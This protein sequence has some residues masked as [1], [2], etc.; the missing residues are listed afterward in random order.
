MSRTKPNIYDVADAA[1]V[2]HQT[3]SRVLNNHPSLRPETRQRVEAAMLNLGYIPSRAARA[4]VTSRSKLIGILISDM[5]LFGPAGIL[6][7]IEVEARRSGYVPFAYSVDP[8]S[9]DDVNAGIAYLRELGVDGVILIVPQALPI[10]VVGAGLLNVPIVTVDSDQRGQLFALHSDNHGGAKLATQHLIDLGHQ[11]I[12]HIT[13]NTAWSVGQARQRGYEDCMRA[14][15]LEP[16]VVEGDWQIATGYDIAKHYE[17]GDITGIVCG[18]D[19]TAL[20]VLRAL[21]E[22]GIDVPGTISV[23]GFDDIPE[24]A[25]FHPPLTTV[26]QDFWAI[27]ELAIKGLLGQLEQGE[28]MVGDLIGLQLIIRE[29]TAHV[30]TTQ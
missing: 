3:V 28:P 30:R 17:F 13:G 18:N 2:S 23:V 19:H 10:D 6:H 25:F 20:G 1:G 26:R 9:A 29:S 7:A 27:G 8:N 5:T 21:R 14:A 24:A 16:V 15:G 11:R 12:L 4:L 22:R